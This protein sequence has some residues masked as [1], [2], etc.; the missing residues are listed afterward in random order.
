[1]DPRVKGRIISELRKK[2]GRNE[3]SGQITQLDISTNTGVHQSQISRFIAGD[4][5]RLS[6]KLKRVCLY[7]G[8][9]WEYSGER[10]LAKNNEVL[11]TSLQR[12]WDGSEKHAKV[13][14]KLLDSISESQSYLQKE[15]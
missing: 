4:F 12:A 3:E 5:V 15:L 14:S 9:S 6:P 1:M 10:K 11:M 7:L 8:I 2:V 13:I